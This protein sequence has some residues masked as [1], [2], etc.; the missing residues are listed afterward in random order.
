MANDIYLPV[1]KTIVETETVGVTLKELTLVAA[2]AESAGALA[3][4][5]APLDENGKWRNDVQPILVRIADK[6]TPDVD[7]EGNDIPIPLEQR[8]AASALQQMMFSAIVTDTPTHQAL[9]IVGMSVWD[10]A[11]LIAPNY[12]PAPEG[13]NGN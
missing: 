2:D 10:A 11:K 5:L 9:G 6:I 3:L 8:Y 1:P 12:L 13:E 7:D 4:A